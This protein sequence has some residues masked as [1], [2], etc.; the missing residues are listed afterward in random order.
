MN[1]EE[2]EWVLNNVEEI[3]IDTK[4]VDEISIGLEHLSIFASEAIKDLA[5]TVLDLQS[6]LDIANKKLDKIK[7]KINDY[8]CIYNKGFP[9]N[10]LLVL[11]GNHPNENQYLELYKVLSEFES[12]IGG[13]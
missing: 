1:K 5:T 9:Y 13:E 7:A 6:Q 10:L 4:D 8:S 2:R 3:C 11:R 12:I